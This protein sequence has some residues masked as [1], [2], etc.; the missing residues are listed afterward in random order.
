[1]NMLERVILTTG[2]TGGHIF[3][4]LAVAEELK[5][6][7]DKVRILFVGGKYGSEKQA[8][9]K[10]GLEFAAVPSAGVLG[11]GL[12][13]VAAAFRLGTGV[14]RAVHLLGRFRPQ[15]VVGFGGYAS[16]PA[17]A[18]AVLRRIPT[19]VHEQ[20]SIP[21]MVNKVLGR[22]ARKVMVSFPGSARYFDAGKTVHT[23]NPV[24]KSIQGIDR[25]GKEPGRHLL[26]LGGSQGARSVNTAVVQG[27]G[28]LRDAGVSITHQTG[29]KDFERIRAV[30][31][32]EGWGAEVVP[33]IEDMA[34]AYGRADLVLCRAGATTA[35]E[36]T[37]AG[38]PSVLVPFPQATHNHQYHNAKHL[39]DV[40]AAV[41]VE[42]KDMPA[43]DP[44]DDVV[45]LLNDAEKRQSMGRAAAE[46]GR[47]R[48]GAEVVQELIRLVPGTAGAVTI[49]AD[50]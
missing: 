19:A 39:A 30:Y 29:D 3:P 33:F 24:R 43:K 15:V 45:H 16:F 50:A 11:R 41:I 21:G 44:I 23:G 4:A 47:P 42:E 32:E 27:L 34:G 25:T 9:E 1:M 7:N 8:A 48:A 2:G 28:K 20:N 38:L 31:S 40:G 12:K 17:T 46:L 22:Y 14:L 6:V 37:A 26:V 5:A 49:K 35:A 10:A 13:G 36:L 18:A